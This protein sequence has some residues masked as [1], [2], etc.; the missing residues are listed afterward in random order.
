MWKVL[1]LSFVFAC[2]STPDTESVEQHIANYPTTAAATASAL[3][4]GTFDKGWLFGSGSTAAASFGGSDTFTRYG[5]TATVADPLNGSASA[6][7]LAATSSNAMSS[8]S[9][10]TVDAT[11]GF[12]LVAYLRLNASTLD[13][14]E[15]V[16][17][18]VREDGDAY[19]Q[20]L[21]LDYDGSSLIFSAYDATWGYDGDVVSVA[22]PTNTWMVVVA[23]IDGSSMRVAVHPASGSPAASSTGAAPTTTFWG[24]GNHYLH[25]PS[26]D[27]GDNDQSMDIKG[28]WVGRGSTSGLAANISSAAAAFYDSI[29]G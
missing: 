24:P 2:A 14:A 12:T 4:Y 6:W 29:D 27:D 13:V 25:L 3:G 7:R 26:D 22:A 9:P 18:L 16:W 23:T 19:F 28:L 17:E 1:L 21:A 8:A 11:A 10:Y 20:T 15:N 5:T